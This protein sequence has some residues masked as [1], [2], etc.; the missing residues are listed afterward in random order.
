VGG[1]SATNY[2]LDGEKATQVEYYKKKLWR[3]KI[4]RLDDTNRHKNQKQK[5]KKKKKNKKKKQKK[6]KNKQKTKKTKK[7][8]KTKQKRKK[9]TTKNCWHIFFFLFNFLDI[10]TVNILHVNLTFFLVNV[11]LFVYTFSL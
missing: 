8:T 3:I 9:N 1:N 10:T 7:K 5:K 6:N 11:W 4:K 2:N